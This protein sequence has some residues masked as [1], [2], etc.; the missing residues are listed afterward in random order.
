LN[1]KQEKDMTDIR[2]TL[3]GLC[4]AATSLG[5]LA[6]TAEEHKDHHPADATVPAKTVKKAPKA[7]PAKPLGAEKMADMDK[8]MKSM[9]AMHDKLMAAKTPEERQAL[10]AEHMK[11]MQ[12]GM[13]MMKDMKGQ[14]GMGGMQ[15]S[16]GMGGDMANRQQMME[17]RMDMMESMMQMM[18]D[19]MPAEASR[20]EV[21]K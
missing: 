15:G 18:M 2:N 8:H 1:F 19:R 16:Q 9:Q 14:G 3:I 20:P 12:E 7:T 5:A 21:A 17:K 4:V 11:M 6:Q 10:M 13:S